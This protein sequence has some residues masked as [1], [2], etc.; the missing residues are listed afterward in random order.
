MSPARRFP[1]PS[2][3]IAALILGVFVALVILIL[4]LGI[5]L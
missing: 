2:E 5:S 1:P 3:L 4:Y